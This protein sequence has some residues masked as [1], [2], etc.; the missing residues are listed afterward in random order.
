MTLP[1]GMRLEPEVRYVSARFG[2]IENS[3]EKRLGGYVTADFKATLPFDLGRY[4]AEAFLSAMNLLDHD[5]SVHFGYPDDGLRVMGGIQIEF[6][7]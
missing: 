1:F 3:S 7:S 2:D 4:K 6:G 5:F